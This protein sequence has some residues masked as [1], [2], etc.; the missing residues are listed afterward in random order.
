MRN[1]FE[2]QTLEVQDNI[3]PA[4]AG[5]IAELRV[6]IPEPVLTH[7][8][9]LRKTG[10]KGVSILRNDTCT[11]CHMKVP[12]NDVLN[13]MHGTDIRVCG[14]CGRY[15]YMTREA[16][17]APAPEAPVKVRKPV[18]RTKKAAA[19]ELAAV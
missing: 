10:K 1:L 4:M 17:M 12:R 7:Y 2:V 5:R 13:V 18:R 15:L 6:T 3:K 14:C 9:R 16:A 19:A 11:A 8:D